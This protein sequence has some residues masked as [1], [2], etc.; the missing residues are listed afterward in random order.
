MNA[1]NSSIWSGREMNSPNSFLS[2]REEYRRNLAI[3]FCL[4]SSADPR[5]FGS[6]EMIPF[7]SRNAIPFFGLMLNMA[8]PCRIIPLRDLRP[9]NSATVGYD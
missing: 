8:A 3:A 7:F 4:S 9:V 6:G 1:F 2:S 5:P